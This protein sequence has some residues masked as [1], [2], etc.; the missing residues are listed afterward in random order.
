[1][2]L[3][4]TVVGSRSCRSLAWRWSVASLFGKAVALAALGRRV[5]R[6]TGIAPLSHIA[7]ATLVGGLIAMALYMVPVIGFIAS[8]LLGVFGLGVVMYTMLLAI[9]ERGA[10]RAPAV[11][12]R[13]AERSGVPAAFSDGWP[14]R[15]LR[16]PPRP[17]HHRC[18]PPA[19][20][21]SAKHRAPASGSAW[22]RCSSTSC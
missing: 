15:R 7:F 1:M 14:N 22:A 4:I 2:L 6:F 16:N 9:R 21:R 5:T 19:T 10:N 11:A 20:P 8:K 18:R 12:A 17:P 3:V 13:H